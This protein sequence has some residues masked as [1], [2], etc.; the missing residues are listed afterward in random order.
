MVFDHVFLFNGT[1]V[2]YQGHSWSTMVNF[3]LRKYE[4]HVT[5]SLF[6][7]EK[8]SEYIHILSSARGYCACVEL[9]DLEVEVRSRDDGRI[10]LYIGGR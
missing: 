3:I 4:V 8:L 6:E 7:N 9:R 5:H 1:T 10:S 2:F